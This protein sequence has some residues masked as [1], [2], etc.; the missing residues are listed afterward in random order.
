MFSGENTFYVFLMKDNFLYFGC[1]STRANLSLDLQLQ[2]RVGVKG[3]SLLV[4]I[5]FHHSAVDSEDN[6]LQGAK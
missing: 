6:A 1:D 5:V 2:S 3:Q 4:A